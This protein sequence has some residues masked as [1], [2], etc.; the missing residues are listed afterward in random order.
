MR[1]RNTII[2]FSLTSLVACAQ[3][4]APAKKT[5]AQQPAQ[6]ASKPAHAASQPAHAASQ[7]AHAAS[8]PGHAASQP[9]HAA[10]Q[11]VAAGPSDAPITGLVKLAEGLPADAIKPTDILFVMARKAISG[12]QP[13]PLVA[14][15]RHANLKLP[16]RYEIGPKDLMMPGVPFA[17]PFVITAR[18]DRDGNPMTKGDDDLYAGQANPVAGGSEGIHMVLSAKPKK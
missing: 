2:V 13:G 10:S 18:V 17:G 3:E 9:G 5:T 11:P 16:M 1:F 15:Q 6:A 14:V 7:P 4:S 8:Q 12:G